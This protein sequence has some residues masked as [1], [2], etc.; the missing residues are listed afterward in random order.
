MP[1]SRPGRPRTEPLRRSVRFSDPPHLIISDP[2]K[3][4]DTQGAEDI[5]GGG[6][7]VVSSESDSDEES[8]SGRESGDV[9][10]QE[11][12]DNHQGDDED[13]GSDGDSTEQEFTI[14]TKGDFSE[15]DSDAVNDADDEASD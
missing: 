11:G 4:V 13:S 6:D 2:V 3:L 9:V 15:S 10:M 1:D 14:F 5:Q 12:A 7:T 8:T